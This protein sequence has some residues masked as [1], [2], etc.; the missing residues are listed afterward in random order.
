[1]SQILPEGARIA[2][3]APSGIHNPEQLYAGMEI[4]TSLGYTLVPVHVDT[5]RH[6]YLAAT[7]SVRRT[8]LLHALRS[9]EFDAVWMTRGGFG[10]TRIIES[11]PQDLPRR[12]VIGF[13]DGTA[14]FARL[15]QSH[16]CVHGPVIHSLPNTTT[17]AREH[18]RNLLQGNSISPLMGRSWHPGSVTAPLVGGNLAMLAALCGT[19]D[20]LNARGKI[21]LIEEVGEAP[22]RIDR[23]LTQL[24]KAGCF[25][26]VA[27]VAFGAFTDCRIPNT[28]DY[29]IPQILIEST[30]NLAIPVIG[31]LPI[32]HGPNNFAFIWGQDATIKKD[33]LSL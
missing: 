4:A 32:G 20:Q 31:D 21:L 28:H 24:H 33:T 26:G 18:L 30:E 23:M 1:M 13:S 3:V 2:M 14:L 6:R 15:H 16:T 12:P 27:G 29:T 8:H 10:L 22:Y 5:P 11:L 19:P 9:P 25:N 7:D 17:E